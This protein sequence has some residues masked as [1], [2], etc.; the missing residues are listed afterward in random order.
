MTL[1]EGERERGEKKKKC[2]AAFT[3][4]IQAKNT[5]ESNNIQCCTSNRIYPDPPKPEWLTELFRTTRRIGLACKNKIT[6]KGSESLRGST[7]F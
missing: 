5:T 1:M 7:P 6:L 3:S 2:K 4:E